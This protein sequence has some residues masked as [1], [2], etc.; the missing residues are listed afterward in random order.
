MKYI[1]P[2]LLIA[3]KSICFSQ[4]SVTITI[5]DLPD[6]HPFD[7]DVYI[8]GSFNGW[9][10][11]DASYLLTLN[12]NNTYSV[13][14]NGTGTIEFKFT[15][16]SWT[17]VEKG[18][19]CE[20]IGNRSYTFGQGNTYDAVVLN[21]ADLCGPDTHTAAENV[22]ILDENFYIPQ[23][24]RLRRIWLYLPPDYETSSKDYPV[25]YMHDGQNL[26]DAYYSFA[27]EWEIDENLNDL[28]DQGDYG[29]I[30][31]GIDNG[32]SERINEYSPW[33]NPTYGGGDG[34]FY[35][36]FIVETL[37]PYI[38]TRY[39]TLSDRGYTGLFGSSLGALISHYGGLEYQEVFSKIGLFSPSFWFSDSCYSMAAETPKEYEMKLYFLGGGQ[40][41]GVIDDCNAMIDTLTAAGYAENELFIKAVE[42]GQHSEWFWRQEFPEAYQWLFSELNTVKTLENESG[43]IYPNP[44]SG[45]FYIPLHAPLNDKDSFD[46]ITVTDI[47]GRTINN[48]NIRLTSDHLAIDL[49]DNTEGI[50]FITCIIQNKVMKYKVLKKM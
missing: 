33:N 10:P 16:G 42:N 38:D 14:L 50:Y 30:V 29:C 43:L 19:S 5:T 3:I 31:V 27:G 44:G 6:N 26:F 22:S 40:E 32:G 41:A 17:S 48:A 7:D 11:G 36:Q 47:S 12:P 35:M 2:L 37:K 1:L 4:S 13:I 23:L 25:M 46:Q 24:D 49:A 21:W 9:N 18:S 45:I 39:R 8:A 28:F 15:R 34:E 20:E